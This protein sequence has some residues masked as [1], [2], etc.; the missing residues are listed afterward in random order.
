MIGYTTTADSVEFTIGSVVETIPRP[1]KYVKID[2]TTN[3]IYVNKEN[4][5]IT[6]EAKN[7][8]I[9]GFTTMTDLYNNLKTLM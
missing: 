5:D 8:P 4:G 3:K 6:F 2:N 9:N 1:L 7:L